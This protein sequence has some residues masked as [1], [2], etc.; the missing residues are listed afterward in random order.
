M[1]NDF[2]PPEAPHNVIIEG[3]QRCSITGVVE[4]ISFDEQEIVVETNRGVIT[5]G[6]TTMH[7]ERLSLDIG[8]L[9]LEGNIDAIVYSD[10]GKQKKGFWSKLF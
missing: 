2:R 8:E 7:V 9:M 3:R 5:V 6:G 1:N 4:V 10:E